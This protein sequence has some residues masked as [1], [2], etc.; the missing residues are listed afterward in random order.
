MYNFDRL[1]ERRNTDCTKWDAIERD[2]GKSNLMPFWVADAD[3]PVLPDIGEAIKK[4]SGEGQTFGYTF[5]GEKFFNSVIDW[6]KRRHNMEVTKEEII[7]VPGVVTGIAI[8]LMALTKEGDKVLINTPVY[9]PFFTVVKSLKR[10]LQESSLIKKDGV[11]SLDFENIEEKFKEGTKAVIFCSPHNPVGRVWSREELETLCKLCRKYGVII[12]S[13]EIHSD[14]V[15]RPAEHIPL[16]NVSQDVVLINS[17]SKTFNIAGLKGSLVFIKNEELRRQF[18]EMTNALH[19]YVNMFSLLATE[20]VYTKGEQ[21]L[22][23]M[24]AYVKGNAELVLKFTEERLVKAKAY[25][26]ESTYLLWL[27]FSGYGMT[28]KELEACVED[29]AGL[30]LNPGTDYGEA[31]GQYMRLNIA[32]PR[33]YLKEGLEK[34]GKAFQDK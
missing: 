27:D 2:Y 14:I 5:A 17:P 33:F 19:L 34:L 26:P 13:D 29:E 24:L 23:E 32:C 20:T 21:W 4:R 15:Y 16:L 22:E 18:S 28:D 8:A 1:L 12:I 3:F 30:A 7:P 11:Y 31:Y 6:N 10:T 25:M 9:A